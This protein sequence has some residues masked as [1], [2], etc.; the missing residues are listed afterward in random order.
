MIKN[1]KKCTYCSTKKLFFVREYSGERL[2]KRCFIKS[3]EN[4]VRSS[5]SKY[6]MLKHNDKIAIAVSG[7]KDSV[8]LLHILAKLEKDYPNAS[9]E[10]ITIDEGIDGYGNEAL[11]IAKK[12]CQK[13]GINHSIVSFK[14][15]FGFTLDTII[16]N[17]RQRNHSKLTPCAY[18]GILRRKAINVTARKIKADKIATAHTLDDEVQTMLLNVLHGDVPRLAQI[19]PITTVTH[20]K[21]VQK[22]KPFSKIPEKEVVL[23]AYLKKVEIQGTPCP[24]SQEALR[25]DI[26]AFLN[27]LE[28]KHTG[29][30]FTLYRSFEKIQPTIEKIVE[31]NE[32]NVCLKC[33]EPT[34]NRICRSCQILQEVE[35]SQNQ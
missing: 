1:E 15:L 25:N 10:A 35:E 28:Q 6:E 27:E 20:T 32:D 33:M 34:T 22:I 19:K 24:Y 23:Y 5:I 14:E 13:L 11:K 26:R 21:F 12:N 16:K 7:G 29:I 30:K 4:K 9:L 3:I 8:S 2:C 18:C 31:K 17:L